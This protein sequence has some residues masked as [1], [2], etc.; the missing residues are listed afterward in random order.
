MSDDCKLTIDAAMSISDLFN[1]HQVIIFARDI[2]TGKIH[3]VTYGK[4]D[5]DAGMAALDGEKISA[6]L[7]ALPVSLEDAYAA[8]AIVRPGD[9]KEENTVKNRKGNE[10]VHRTHCCVLH[11]CKYGDDNCPVANNRIKQDYVCETCS[12]EEFTLA[13]AHDTYNIRNG[14]QKTCS[15]LSAKDDVILG[16][17]KKITKDEINALVKSF[18]KLLVETNK[19]KDMRAS[20]VKSLADILR[21]ALVEVDSDLIE[22]M[23]S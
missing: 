7:E 12:A 22:Q 2:T 23:A 20:E 11:G 1:L 16:V 14:L 3:Q 21:V 8:A 9:I 13:D 18:C 10:G 19:H 6:M 4:T 5:M 15:Y 17:R